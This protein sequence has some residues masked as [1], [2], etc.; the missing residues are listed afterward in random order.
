M[1]SYTNTQWDQIKLAL[2]HLKPTDDNLQ[3]ARVDLDRAVNRF[4]ASFA[5]SFS[6][7]TVAEIIKLERKNWLR[8]AELVRELRR[9]WKN[10]DAYGPPIPPGCTPW[11]GD[12]I[13]D[14]GLLALDVVANS[15]CAIKDG[16]DDSPKA[17]G[18]TRFHHEVLE[19]WTTLG[20]QLK[21]SRHPTT[22][23]ITG[24]L[25]RY[26]K[27][28]T[29]CVHGGS[30]ESLPGI[31]ARHRTFA[32][33]LR[34]WRARNFADYYGEL[35]ELYARYGWPQGLNGGRTM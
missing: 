21:F 1:N 30:L 11:K 29:S 22:H 34:E 7:P 28:A 23:K 24:P 27:A 2:Q 10:R 3:R 9:L 19:V 26:F 35:A 17:S 15:R 6:G 14:D 12:K 20:G 33:E 25:A 5:V 13:I 4:L 16:V 31:I 32:M 8:M 18:R